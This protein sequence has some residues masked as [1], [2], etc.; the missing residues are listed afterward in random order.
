MMN[1]EQELDLE[2]LKMANHM[3]LLNLRKNFSNKKNGDQD[4]DMVMKILKNREQLPE[5]SKFVI[6]VSLK[7]EQD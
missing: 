1:N 5:I 4:I 3:C 7:D 6:K 2:Q